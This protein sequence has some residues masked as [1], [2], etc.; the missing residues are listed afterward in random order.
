MTSSLCDSLAK[1]S[2]LIALSAIR[3]GCPIDDDLLLGEKQ[4]A[5]CFE[6]LDVRLKIANDVV[7]VEIGR[8]AQVFVSI[9]SNQCRR[10]EHFELILKNADLNFLRPPSSQR[11]LQ[12]E[13][14]DRTQSGLTEQCRIKHSI[15]Q[16]PQTRGAR[17]VLTVRP[18]L[19]NLQ[20]DRRA[21]HLLVLSFL[22]RE[23]SL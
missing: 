15:Q 23:S 14:I 9:E 11:L 4:F 5:F 3:P 1:S 6:R 16:V 20:F 19:S 17:I 2:V 18:G 22:D 7:C 8:L 21:H 13:L 10:I 12:S